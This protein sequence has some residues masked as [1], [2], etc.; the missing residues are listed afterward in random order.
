MQ[1]NGTGTYPIHLRAD[2]GC[3]L[4]T[5]NTGASPTAKA[6]TLSIGGLP[7]R[8]LANS[9]DRIDPINGSH[10]LT[11]NWSALDF[12]CLTVKQS[13]SWNPGPDG[14]KGSS[15]IDPVSLLAGVPSEAI[16]S[17]AEAY[18]KE[19]IEITHTP[20]EFQ[21]THLTRTKDYM[22]SLGVRR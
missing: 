10:M 16:W 5:D 18:L 6:E 20:M 11:T 9:M 3:K 15:S 8:T 2:F 17:K 13:A 22:K 7:V 4:P 12:D 14:S 21:S 1:S 19:P